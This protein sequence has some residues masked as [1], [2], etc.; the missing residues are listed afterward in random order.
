M[1]RAWRQRRPSFS[2]VVCLH[3]HRVMLGIL[4]NLP[5]RH[6]RTAEE[7]REGDLHTSPVIS[8]SNNTNPRI[9]ETSKDRGNGQRRGTLESYSKTHAV[10]LSKRTNQPLT[11]YC[12]TTTIV[13]RLLLYFIRI[14]IHTTVQPTLGTAGGQGNT[15]AEKSEN[16]MRSHLRE[17]RGLQ[18]SPLY[19]AG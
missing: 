1:A 2:T 3:E 5:I 18:V 17:Q 8:P 6:T 11:V 7:S 9:N 15:N 19:A 14:T 13:V 12:C 16:E 4:Y 10:V